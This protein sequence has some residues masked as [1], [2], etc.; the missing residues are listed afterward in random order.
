MVKRTDEEIYAL[1]D[2]LIDKM[3]LPEKIGQIVQKP[4][5]NTLDLGLLED[6]GVVKG[7]KEGRVGMIILPAQ[8]KYQTLYDLQKLA[9]EQ[10]RLGIPLLFNADVIHGFVTEFPLPIAASCSWDPEIVEE[11]CKISAEETTCTGINY[12][13]APM[14]DIARDPRWGRIAE[15][16]GEDPYLGEVMA[17]AQVRGFQGGKGMENLANG[18]TMIAT[19][20]HYVGYGAAEGG[21]DYNTCEISDNTLYNV[22]LRPFKAGVEEGAGSVMSSFNTINNVPVSGSRRMLKKILR[23]EFGFKGITIS[24]ANSL[25]ET[26]PHGYCENAVESG[27]RGVKAT[28]SLE[29]ASGCFENAIPRLLEEGRIT[30]EE[31]DALV[32]YNLYIKYVTGVM[33]DPFMYFDKERIEKQ[34]SPENLEVARRAAKGSIVMTKNNGVLPIAKSKKIALIGPFG[35]NH[36]MFGC[37]AASPKRNESVT[38]LEGLTAAGYDVTCVAGSDVNQELSGGIEEAVQAAKNADVVLLALG[39]TS[40]QSGEAHSKCD[41][42]IPACQHKLAQAVKAVGKPTV[43]LLTTGRPLTIGW[44]EENM[45]GIL[46]TWFLGSMAGHGIADVLSGDHNPS[47]KLS[48]TFPKSVGQI[49]LY[50]NY[51][52][53]GR[54]VNREETNGNLRNIYPEKFCPTYIDGDHLPLYPF[55]YGLSYSKFEYS[56][57]KV[58]SDTLKRGEKITVSATLKNVSQVDGTETVQLYLRDLFATAVRPVKELCGFKKVAVKAGEAVTVS[59][60]VTEDILKYYNEDLDYVAEPGD[61]RLFIGGDSRVSE[62][63]EFKLVD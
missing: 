26:M 36:D 7:V 19:L 27:Y 4:I 43:L 24:D 3:T 59:F 18:H 42:D 17:R 16:A 6:N 35:D 21:R 22:Y 11:T 45:D 58:S 9:V 33:D 12:T 63:A 13:N 29:M 51:L 48:V 20:K 56:D 40:D 60:D 31:V 10:T 41:L 2:R 30:M 46:I 23:D 28:M 5:G 38:M 44:Y 61:F 37:W 47:A 62:Y 1:V 53:T 54:P 32:R 34:Y 8:N 49:P 15:G 14:V 25:Y 57:I 39:E 50:Y 52:N 55:G